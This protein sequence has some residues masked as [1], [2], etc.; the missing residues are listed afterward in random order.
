MFKLRLA[1]LFILFA[2]PLDGKM[3]IESYNAMC[4]QEYVYSN[5]SLSPEGVLNV[6]NQVFQ[7][8]NFKIMVTIN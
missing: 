5:I 6:T 4:N 1:F 2:D 8:M 7:D 3:V